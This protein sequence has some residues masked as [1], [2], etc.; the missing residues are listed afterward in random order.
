MNTFT[1]TDNYQDTDQDFE[2]IISINNYDN[3]EDELDYN[4]D[5]D[6]NEL[7]YELASRK[8]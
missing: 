5:Y 6:P 2:N 7:Y 3:G 1:Y 8:Y 4:F